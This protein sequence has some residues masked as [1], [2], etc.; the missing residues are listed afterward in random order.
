MKKK[1]LQGYTF[2]RNISGLAIPTNIQSQI[3]RNYCEMNDYNF[4]LHLDEFCLKNSY[5]QLFQILKNKKNINSIGM[6]SIYFLPENKNLMKKIFTICKK[7]K[8]EIIFIFENIKFK[9]QNI[10]KF[11]NEIKQIKKI[12][13]LT[14][15]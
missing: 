3:I 9:N 12:N 10:N 7:R 5:V 6:C 11:I 14:K 2:T 1:S 13:F 4:K 15:K 8:L